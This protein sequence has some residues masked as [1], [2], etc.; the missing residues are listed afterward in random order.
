VPG[1]VR[2]HRSKPWTK[3]GRRKSLVEQREYGK[4]R[5]EPESLGH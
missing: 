4:E 3:E 2:T 5:D 1:A